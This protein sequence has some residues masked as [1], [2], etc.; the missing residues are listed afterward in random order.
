MSSMQRTIRRAI[1]RKKY[2]GNLHGQR[3][4]VKHD[5]FMRYFRAGRRHRVYQSR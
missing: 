5:E 1:E 2:G 3:R 4:G